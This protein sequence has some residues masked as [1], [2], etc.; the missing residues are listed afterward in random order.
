MLLRC[1]GDV[2]RCPLCPAG[3]TAGR[4]RL[5]RG[6]RFMQGT[7]MQQSDEQADSTDTCVSLLTCHIMCASVGTRDGPEQMKLIPRFD[8]QTRGSRQNQPRR[9]TDAC[10]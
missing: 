3:S 7:V 9:C 1:T 8:A 2:P 4:V 6:T 5:F 10:V